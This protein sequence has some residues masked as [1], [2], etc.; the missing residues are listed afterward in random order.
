MVPTRGTGDEGETAMRPK[1]ILALAL[2][3]LA[4]TA[5]FGAHRPDRAASIVV[6]D[7]NVIGSGY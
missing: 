3:L 1:L 5:L 6:A 2:G 7:G 4:V